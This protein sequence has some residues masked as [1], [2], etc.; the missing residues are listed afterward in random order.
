MRTSSIASRSA[1]GSASDEHELVAGALDRRAGR[2]AGD[3]GERVAA[4]VQL[5]S[6]NATS[7]LEAD[8]LGGLVGADA[9]PAAAPNDASTSASCGRL[10]RH[11]ARAPGVARRRAGKT[12][13]A[14]TPSTR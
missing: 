7:C 10:R 2:L 4:G 6:A 8:R 11:P 5:A 14:T 1:N 12:R 13:L 3:G 9:A